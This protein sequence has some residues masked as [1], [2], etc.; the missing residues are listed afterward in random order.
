ML[1]LD[2]T[3]ARIAKNDA[4]LVHLRWS[5]SCLF[6][7]GAIA[8]STALEHNSTLR[9]LVLDVNGI[10][11]NGVCA[12]A[13]VLATNQTLVEVDLSRNPFGDDGARALA[14]ALKRNKTL[15]TLHLNHNWI[16]D[17]GARAL[18]HVLKR[19][20]TLTAIYLYRNRINADGARALLHMLEYNCTL[21]A[22]DLCFNGAIE[23]EPVSVSISKLV[24]RNVDMSKRKREH[25]HFVAFGYRIALALRR[26]HWHRSLLPPR[27]L[28]D[29]HVCAQ[30]I[31]ARSL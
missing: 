11:D 10:T 21:T 29:V 16:A 4:S 30:T 5:N 24:T 1:S 25:A 13:R 18:A 9:T 31:V 19:N 6:D 14:N 27:I 15:A 26:Q 22:Y 7:N 8:L 20:T 28:N 2:V 17:D 12:L 23:D 3:L